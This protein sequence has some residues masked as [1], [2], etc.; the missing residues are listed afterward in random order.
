MWRLIGTRTYRLSDIDELNEYERKRY[1]VL[2][3]L[4][5]PGHQEIELTS[6]LCEECGFVIYTPRPSEEDIQAKYRFLSSFDGSDSISPNSPSERR[7]ANR[8]YRN[9][10]GFLPGNRTA[11]VL[12]FGG[13]DGRLM[14]DFVT[15][16]CESYL[17]DYSEEVCAGITRLGSTESDIPED[18]EFDLI[19]C[20][21][22]IEHVANPLTVLSKLKEFLRLNGT[23]Y[24]E[25]PMEIWGGAPL[26]KE[27]V[28]HVNF[29]TS[30]STRRLFDRA[31]LSS[32]SCKMGSSPHPSG[33]TSLV[34]RAIGGIGTADGVLSSAEAVAEVDRLLKPGL[35]LRLKRRILMP[36]TV[37]KAIAYK[38][39]RLFQR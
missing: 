10:K 22:V 4:W 17:V 25:V 8:L 15:S 3:E 11:R 29:F 37:P 33:H 12:D 39:K 36:S 23:I 18:A 2:F 20:S 14:R 6:R 38:T 1:R 16:G 21:H 19:V 9:L 5:F 30:A 28:T 13:G 34:I 35:P 7:R 32:L 31:G 27:P 26:Q 24:V